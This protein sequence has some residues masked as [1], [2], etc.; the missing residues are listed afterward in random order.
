MELLT[1]EGLRI[2]GRRAREL[3]SIT[4]KYVDGARRSRYQS[5]PCS[6]ER[7]AIYPHTSLLNPRQAS[8]I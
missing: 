2:D 3:R 7:E 6:R 4:C 1:P 8:R 5:R